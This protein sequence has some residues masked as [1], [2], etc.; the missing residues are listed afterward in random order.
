MG[1][2][3]GPAH[4]RAETGGQG[5]VVAGTVIL[6]QLGRAGHELTQ[7]QLLNFAARFLQIHTYGH[8]SHGVFG[9]DVGVGFKLASELLALVALS[10][11]K[12]DLSLLHRFILDNDG[13]AQTVLSGG[14][15]DVAGG[16]ILAEG[17][18]ANQQQDW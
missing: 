6:V 1:S 8:V 17:G 2:V 5:V 13:P 16:N 14:R 10:R 9:G 15:D 18:P 12:V 4:L 7:K 3:E 11:D